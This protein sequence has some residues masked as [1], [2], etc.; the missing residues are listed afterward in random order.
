MIAAS[1]A[2]KT[3]IA[4]DPGAAE[5]EVSGPEGPVGTGVRDEPALA[6]CIARSDREAASTGDQGELGWIATGATPLAPAAAFR[7]RRSAGAA[8]VSAVAEAV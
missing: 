1:A 4:P 6:V 3:R 5:T 2:K 7:T 8:G